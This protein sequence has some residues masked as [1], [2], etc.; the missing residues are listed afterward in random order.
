MKTNVADLRKG[1]WIDYDSKVL[2]VQA[3]TS[4]HSGRGARSF[5]VSNTLD[6][7]YDP[8]RM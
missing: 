1:D 6:M 8:H 3:V 5:L 2:I 4:A 7:P